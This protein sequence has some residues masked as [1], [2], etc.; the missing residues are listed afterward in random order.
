MRTPL[1]IGLP[2][3]GQ[4]PAKKVTET[5]EAISIVIKKVKENTLTWMDEGH[6]STPAKN[7]KQ[8]ERAS[9]QR[10]RERELIR[11]QTFLDSSA[12]STLQRSWGPWSL[13]LGIKVY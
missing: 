4:C 1:I 3:F 11:T 9:L 5:N 7:N 8:R 13:G 10:E 2:T 12:G 6:A